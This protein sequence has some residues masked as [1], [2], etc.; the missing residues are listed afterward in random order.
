M[1][2]A[3]PP[4]LAAGKSDC[5]RCGGRYLNADLRCIA[6]SADFTPAGLAYFRA[7]PAALARRT[8]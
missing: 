7:L 5:P 1:D 6:C 8:A 2:A 4:N 3:P